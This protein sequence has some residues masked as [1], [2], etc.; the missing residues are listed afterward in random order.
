MEVHAVHGGV[1]PEIAARAHLDAI[2]LVIGRAMETAGVT[3]G[4]LDGRSH[5]RT[6][7][8]RR[9]GCRHSGRQGDRHGAR[10]PYYAVNIWRATPSARGSSTR[11]AFPIFFCWYQADTHS[12][13]PCMR[14]DL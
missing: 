9:G 7:P 13:W 4:D 6:R 8:D 14:R 5:W 2:D 10:I 12:F 11:S 3:M 1:V